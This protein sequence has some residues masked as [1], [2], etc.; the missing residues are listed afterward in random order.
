MEKERAERI[1]TLREQGCTYKQ[2]SERL[3]IHRHTIDKALKRK[4]AVKF[5]S[6]FPYQLSRREVD[7]ARLLIV[8]KSVKLIAELLKLKVKTVDSHIGTIYLKLGINN[9]PTVCKRTVTILK[10]KDLI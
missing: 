4:L 7:V 3:G 5:R 6:D 10:L 2:I 1:V 8:G 9:D